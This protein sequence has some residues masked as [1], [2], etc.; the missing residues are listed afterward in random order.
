MKYSKDY[1]NTYRNKKQ[2]NPLTVAIL[3]STVHFVS[4]RNYFLKI[5]SKCCYD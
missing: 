1:K 4:R 5:I 2:I 3:K